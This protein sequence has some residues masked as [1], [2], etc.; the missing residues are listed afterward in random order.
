VNIELLKKQAAL[1]A[2]EHVQSGMTIG[3]GSGSTA[4]YFIQALGEKLKTGELKNVIGVPSSKRSETLAIELDVP[5]VELSSEGVDVAID[6]MDEV[7]PQLNAIKGLGGA[8]TREKIV[9]SSA[10]LFILIGDETKTVTQL[11]EKAPIPVEVI[12]FGYKATVAKLA[13]LGTRPEQRMGTEK[14]RTGDAPFITDNGN[15][16][17]HCHVTPPI[18]ANVLAN[19]ISSIPGVVEHGLFLGMAKIAYVATSTEV[20]KLEVK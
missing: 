7:D 13:A 16:I 19:Q 12:P 9:A 5:L 2:L 8:Q 15:Y 14:G 10:R 1:Q 11:G 18:D 20:L 17:F 4:T 3:L 6:G